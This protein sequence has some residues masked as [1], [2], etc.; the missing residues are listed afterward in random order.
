[1]SKP[2]KVEAFGVS[3]GNCW[4]TD[5]T[6]IGRLAVADSRPNHLDAMSGEGTGEGTGVNRPTTDAWHFL[7]VMIT[8]YYH[9]IK[10]ASWTKMDHDGPIIVGQR[11]SSSYSMS[12]AQVSWSRTPFLSVPGAASHA[13]TT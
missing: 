3:R 5:L 6:S 7:R 13:V 10:D 4:G 11:N 9:E 12:G 1:M 2:S 8:I